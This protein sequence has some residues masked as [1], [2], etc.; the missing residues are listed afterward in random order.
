M[1]C[2]SDRLILELLGEGK[3]D[4]EIA[5]RL[6]ISTEEAK[7]RIRNLMDGRGEPRRAELSMPAA[8]A[9]LPSRR[10]RRFAGGVAVVGI[11]AAAV[12]LWQFYS[13]GRHAETV[14][15]ERTAPAALSPAS[16][17]PFQRLS[18]S[19]SLMI[20]LGMLISAP[21]AGVEPVTQLEARDTMAVASV[22]DGAVLM[23]AVVDHAWSLAARTSDGLTFTRRNGSDQLFVSASVESGGRL[24]PLGEGAVVQSDTAERP[25]T[26]LLTADRIAGGKS[27]ADSIHIDKDGTVWVSIEP[28][29]LSAAIV[30]ST[31]EI[32]KTDQTIWSSDIFADASLRISMQCPGIGE[33]CVM[34]L[35]DE[36]LFD[37]KHIIPAP[38][39][40]E[41][42][43]IENGSIQLES[44]FVWT[45][46]LTG[47]DA[48]QAIRCSTTP[49]RQ[50]AIGEPMF[51]SKYVH[52]AVAM[53]DGAPLSIVVSQ[54]GKVS[55][56]HIFPTVGC[57]CRK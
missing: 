4:A 24:V 49:A 47:Q 45:F 12:W 56:G 30:Y 35:A 46:T 55:V 38:V 50:V 18:V 54:D 53:R 14:P 16:Q 26:L 8:G 10:A 20:S 19:G 25:V 17:P 6:G 51:D 28:V 29:S 32:L 1:N 23:P 39:S 40:G 43:C 3:V 21:A 37:D 48:R 57:P 36:V 11:L 9:A 52:V 5:V 7:L 13:V 34:D 44:D 33:P 27:L 42:T 15:H 22:V 41:L 2:E 31:G